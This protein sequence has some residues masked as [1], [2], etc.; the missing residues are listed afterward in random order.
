MRSAE[1]LTAICHRNPDADT[2]GGAIAMVLAA[3]QLGLEARLVSTDP[4]PQVFEYMPLF[5]EAE[6]R[7]DRDPGLVVVCDAAT[8]DRVGPALGAVDRSQYVLANIDHH[9]TNTMF[10]DV[11]CV[12]PTSAATCQLIA[13]MLPDLGVELD[14]EIATALLTGVVRDSHGFADRSTS[15]Q[16]LRVAAMLVEAGGDLHDIHRR[17]LTD[18]PYTTLRLWGRLLTT[19]QRSDDG[20]VVYA[21]LYNR[22]L[23]ET[24]TGQEDADGFAEFLAGVRDADISVLLRE[25]TPEETRVSLRVRHGIDA[26]KIAARFGGGGHAARAGA[27]IACDGVTAAERVLAACS[28]HGRDGQEAFPAA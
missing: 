19:M 5:A 17:I 12:D 1:R 3:R 10:G 6:A 8:I 25:L 4:L 28:Q 15:P 9:V 27:T 23:E 2:V 24:G 16:T 21:T 7:A 22:M 13:E 14:A 20:R 18:L 26:S 11:N